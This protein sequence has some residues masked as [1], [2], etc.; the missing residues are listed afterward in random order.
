MAILISCCAHHFYS[1]MYCLVLLSKN[2]SWLLDLDAYWHV[3]SGCQ[4]VCAR[5]LLAAL[6]PPCQSVLPL[7]RCN[8]QAHLK[9]QTALMASTSRFDSQ[10]SH[11]DLSVALPSTLH[12]PI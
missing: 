11:P 1:A 8:Q 3:R 12:P 6:P 5:S 9:K 4:P 2:A 10:A 7:S